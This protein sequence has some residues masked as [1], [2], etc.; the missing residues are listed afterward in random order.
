MNYH[1]VSFEAAYGLHQQIP[2]SHLPEVAFSGRSNVGKSSLINRLLAKQ[3]SL[4]PW[5]ALDMPLELTGTAH[6]VFLPGVL[7]A[8]ADMGALRQNLSETASDNM[9][10]ML[11]EIQEFFNDGQDGNTPPPP[12][13]S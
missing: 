3:A 10:E 11:R 1:N 9:Q 2:V 7:P 12:N 5:K 4:R 6:T 8:A 13:N